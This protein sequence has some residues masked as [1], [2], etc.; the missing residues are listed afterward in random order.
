MKINGKITILCDED[1]VKI[2]VLDNDADIQ[3]LEIR[4]TPRQFTQALGRLAHTECMSTEVR[5][6]DLVGKVAE[7]KALVFEIPKDLRWEH[8]P[9]R[10]EALIKLA[11]KACPK[12]WI[13]D[14]YFGSRDS[15]LEKDGKYFAQTHLR[16]WVER[17]KEE[18]V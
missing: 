15:F 9:K 3:F 8:G 11:D 16:R 1:G 7:H 12:G 13:H 5:G 4:L 2:E 14:N 18:K 17:K 10:D 6:L